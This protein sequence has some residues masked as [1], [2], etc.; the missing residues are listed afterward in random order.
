[1]ITESVRRVVAI[2]ATSVAIVLS[3]I[4]EFLTQMPPAWESETAGT[5]MRFAGTAGGTLLLAGAV[6][7]TFP[8]ILA[9]RWRRIA[10]IAALVGWLF[11]ELGSMTWS[12][13]YDQMHLDEDPSPF[14]SSYEFF[15]LAGIVLMAFSIG[16]FILAPPG[17]SGGRWVIAILSAS[18]GLACLFIAAV[19]VRLLLPV[20]LLAALVV[21]IL[22]G[23]EG[24]HIDVPGPPEGRY[25]APQG[26]KTED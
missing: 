7:L 19:V 12:L 11:I 17:R 15:F 8:V 13:G 20:L 24:R 5:Y 9:T 4:M 2:T 22:V 14:A 1:M 3:A 10:S 6:L 16:A 23:R 18:L 25:A 21:L 26:R